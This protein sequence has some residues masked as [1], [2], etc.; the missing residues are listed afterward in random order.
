MINKENSL[1]FSG[2]RRER[3]PKNKKDMRKLKHFL[4]NEIDNAIKNGIY[5]F[6]FGACYG[7]DLMCADIVLKRRIIINLITP[8]KIKLIAVIPFEKQ[9]FLWKENDISL[10]KNILKQCDRV[11]TLNKE[12]K[13]GC[14]FERNRYMVD[15]SGTLICYYN[16]GKG[17][18]AYTVD[19][20]KENN[21]K[22]INL[23]N[24]LNSETT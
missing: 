20:A 18:T 15:H 2:H 14:Y 12:H 4:S 8:V 1:C 3:L 23:Y 24:K 6:Y 22:I 16:G 5:T 21:L 11:I 9:A 19:Y 10:Y 17:G 13:N 7:F